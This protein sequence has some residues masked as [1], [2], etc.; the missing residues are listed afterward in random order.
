MVKKR[1]RAHLRKHVDKKLQRRLWLYAGI[2]LVLIVIV[3]YEV[4]VGVM[5]LFFAAI[6]VGIGVI[7]GILSA[8]MFHISWDHDAQLIVSKL[9]QFGIVILVL[10]ILV[11]IF[12]G[13]IVGHF[14]HGPAVGG[15]SLSIATGVMLGRVIGTRGK[16]LKVL[17]QQ[18][19]I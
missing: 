19:I 14:I 16:I 9:D 7:L 13:Q 5:S 4:A 1:T 6:G 11:S 17:K 18:G 10:Y 15:V 8:R 3:L 2:S 12:R